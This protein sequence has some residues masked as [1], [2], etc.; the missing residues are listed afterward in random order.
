MEE[1]GIVNVPERPQ[2][3][4]TNEIKVT[5]ARIPPM[6]RFKVLAIN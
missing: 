4:A 6:L 1:P 2:R 3:I 5:T